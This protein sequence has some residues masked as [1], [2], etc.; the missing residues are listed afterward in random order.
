[1]VSP[2]KFDDD[3][4]EKTVI[5]SIISAISD[6]WCFRNFLKQYGDQYAMETVAMAANELE[7]RRENIFDNEGRC[8]NTNLIRRY[9]F[10]IDEI[11]QASDIDV[12]ILIDQ[13]ERIISSPLIDS[14]HMTFLGES[15]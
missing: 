10:L 4:T 13:F 14:K 8:V 1:M 15:G 12:C 2:L 11:L 6:D 9:I 7:I 3:C 5:S